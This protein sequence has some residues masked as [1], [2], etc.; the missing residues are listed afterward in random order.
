MKLFLI[1]VLTCISLIIY[2]AEHLFVCPLATYHLW[3]NIFRFPAPCVVVV[4]LPSRIWLFATSW[5]AALQASLSPRVCSNSRPLSQWCYLTIF[6]CP[7][8]LLPS[9]FSNIRVFSSEL[10]LC[11]GWPKFWNFNFSISSSNK[12]SG[13]ISSR[14]DWFE[15]PI[16]VCLKSM[17]YYNCRIQGFKVDH[18]QC[19]F[20]A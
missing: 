6:C 13:W 15:G 14:I 2:D 20:E 18:S 5:T 10:V 8:L 3:K 12:Y 11:I 17:M 1:V 19:L 9:I 16:W 7:L 4:Q